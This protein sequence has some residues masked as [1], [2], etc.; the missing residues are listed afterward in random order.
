MSDF[1]K[2]LDIEGAIEQYLKE[3]L[4]IEIESETNYMYES[5]TSV[6]VKLLLDGEEISSAIEYLDIPR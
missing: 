4:T 6:K 1:T 5:T 2:R 3:N